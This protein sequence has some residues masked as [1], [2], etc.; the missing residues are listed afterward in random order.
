[1]LKSRTSFVIATVLT[2]CV[3]VG[4]LFAT[5]NDANDSG[6][7]K[8]IN[9][10]MDLSHSFSFYNDGKFAEQYIPNQTWGRNC[11]S[12][13]NLNINEAQCNLLVL[14]PPEKDMDYTREDIEVIQ[15]YLNQGGTVIM[16]MNQTKRFKE[17]TAAFGVDMAPSI[18]GKL[19]S[20]PGLAFLATQPSDIKR[21]GAIDPLSFPASN[22]NDWT[23]YIQGVAPNGDVVPVVASRNVGPGTLLILPRNLFSQDPGRSDAGMNKEWIEPL[24]Q[25]V[26]TQTV[27]APRAK[28][29]DYTQQ[30]TAITVDGITFHYSTYLEK[31]YET[32]RDVMLDAKPLI[33][34]RMGVDLHAA[35]GSDIALIATDGGGFSSGRVVALAVFW[36]NFPH[37]RKGMYEFLT[38]EMVHSWVAPHKEVW[39]EPIATYVGDLVMGD[40]GYPEEG[41]KRIAKTIKRATRF[42]PEMKLYDLNG[43]STNPKVPVLNKGQKNE[44]H[45]GKTFWIFEEL[46][47]EQPDFL[48]KYFQAKREHAPATL[49]QYSIN[50]TVM[51]ISVAMGKNM[52]PW[53]NTH[54]IPCD[55]KNSIITTIDMKKLK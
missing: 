10:I 40:A 19:Q 53:F 36:E 3:G 5:Q 27:T 11:G 29:K 4:S 20:G 43:E 44:I 16:A 33:R 37:D 8:K 52:Y 28:G 47:K 54:G 48:A 21:R 26:V 31:C 46:R 55:P 9:P 18:N 2:L 41:N 51:I 15:S 38:H 30:D 22:A 17:F 45:W 34:K 7:P 6:K 35:N 12:L 42:D 23:V 25:K 24:V 32:M 13:K 39:N 1:M 14:F 49:K 50:E